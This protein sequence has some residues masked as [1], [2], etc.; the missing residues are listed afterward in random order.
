[1]SFN[2][3]NNARSISNIDQYPND[4]ELI[5]YGDSVKKTFGYTIE[6]VYLNFTGIPMVVC[7]RDGVNVTVPPEECNMLS[8]SAAHRNKFLILTYHRFGRKMSSDKCFT[9]RY[10]L[11]PETNNKRIQKYMEDLDKLTFTE[12]PLCNYDPKTSNVIKQNTVI[13]MEMINRLEGGF[14]CFEEDVVIAKQDMPE[15]HIHPFQSENSIS[16]KSD[17]VISE[18]SFELRLNDCERKFSDKVYY[19]IGNVPCYIATTRDCL[20]ENGLYVTFKDPISK[21]ITNYHYPIEEIIDG[22]KADKLDFGKPIV[23]RSRH[24]AVNYGRGDD[25]A[26]GTTMRLK[27][28]LEAAKAES[29]RQKLEFEE[30]TKLLQIDEDKLKHEKSKYEQELKLKQDEFDRKVKLEEMRLKNIR[31]DTLAREKHQTEQW[32]GML[33][34]ASG[35]FGI[36]MVVLKR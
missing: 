18:T 33:T 24:D 9:N 3:R 27:S 36:L 5:I 4:D 20:L 22:S 19:M 23:Y 7:R 30:R 12:N 32:K 14:Y 17:S 34:I 6:K 16:V 25:I 28:E 15:L 29:Q 21:K 35:I 2:Y 8:I 26:K 11:T 31:E 13:S 1:M 10:S